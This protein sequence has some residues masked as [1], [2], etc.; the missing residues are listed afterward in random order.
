MYFALAVLCGALI[1]VMIAINGSLTL[2]YG[3]YTST[4]MIHLVGLLFISALLLLRRQ[5]IRPTVRLP[6]FM[7]I[8]GA[9]G[10]STTVFNNLSFG[11]ISMSALLALGLLGQS[12]CS[13]L[14]DQ[15][16][17]LGMGR[18]PFRLR[19]L[20]GLFV[21]LAGIGVMIYP[22]QPSA[23]LA[24]VVSFLAGAS[25]V[26]SRTF[27][28]GLADAATVLQ[29]TFYN[30]LVGIVVCTPVWLLASGNEPRIWEVGLSSNPLIYTGGLFGVLIICILNFTV[31]K[32][33]SYYMSLANFVGQVFA[34]LAL[35][36]WLT[37]S[38]SQQNLI[39]GVLVS[40]GLCFDMVL[41]RCIQNKTC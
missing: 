30:Y 27:N 24:I 31:S 3:V 17:F 22:V 11:K 19:R 18:Q 23:M 41:E 35:D 33:P 9:I 38:I 13:L 1:A 12:I 7:F 16:G 25:I 39:G 36:A 15:F 37:N 8:G 14:F 28:A 2:L 40:V 10:V 5:P 21:V 29:S 4:W 32:I 6:W 26:V 20:W 34:G